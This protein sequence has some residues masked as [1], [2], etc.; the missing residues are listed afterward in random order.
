[1]NC[2]PF[3][4]RAARDANP[5]PPTTT[6]CANYEHIYDKHKVKGF[7]LLG[8]DQGRPPSMQCGTTKVPHA[9]E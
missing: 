2:V 9:K 8:W 5:A 1:M 3:F 6:T 7:L 4:K